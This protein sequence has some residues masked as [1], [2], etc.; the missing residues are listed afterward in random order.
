MEQLIVKSPRNIFDM[1]K[2]LYIEL[3]MEHLR[4]TL[5]I[6]YARVWLYLTNITI[7][8]HLS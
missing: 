4:D 8:L 6:R 2:I 1:C 5:Q 3:P 7:N